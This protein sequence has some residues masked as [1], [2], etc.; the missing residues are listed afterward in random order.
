MENIFLNILMIIII[1]YK[2]ISP[3]PNKCTQICWLAALKVRYHSCFDSAIQKNDRA[4]VRA[5]LDGAVYLNMITWINGY[6]VLVKPS[7]NIWRYCLRDLMEK[8]HN[9]II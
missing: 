3:A 1:R 5:N 8:M 7:H 4:F 2:L 6:I 9:V